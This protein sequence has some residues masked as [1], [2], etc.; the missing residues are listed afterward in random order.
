MGVVGGR[1]GGMVIGAPPRY[2]PWKVS[3]S[4]PGDRFGGWSPISPNGRSAALR[5][6][7]PRAWA[8]L[9]SNQRP[10]ACEASALPLSYA[11]GTGAESLRGLGVQGFRAWGWTAPS[12]KRPEK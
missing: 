10:L 9:V 3:G 11:P 12:D 5:R 2:L 1:R 6:G 4:L 7:I 8:R